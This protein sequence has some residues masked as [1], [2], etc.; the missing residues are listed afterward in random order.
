MCTTPKPEAIDH[1]AFNVRDLPNIADRVEVPFAIE[2]NDE[3]LTI[4]AAYRTSWGSSVEV[5]TGDAVGDLVTMNLDGS[6]MAEFADSP[7]V[8]D[9]PDEVIAYTTRDGEILCA[10]HGAPF[11]I[12]V[13]D[14]AVY[15]LFSG[16]GA[17]LDAVEYCSAGTDHGH[18]FCGSCGT[19]L[20]TLKGSPGRDVEGPFSRCS[21]CDTTS[22]YVDGEGFQY[23]DGFGSILETMTA[24]VRGVS[25]YCQT[26]LDGT[27]RIRE[28]NADN[29]PFGYYNGLQA[30]RAYVAWLEPDP[31][32]GM[33]LIICESDEEAFETADEWAEEKLDTS[34]AADEEEAESMLSDH[35]ADTRVVRV[36]VDKL[37]FSPKPRTYR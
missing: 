17:N 37:D 34:D 7:T 20:E 3:V 30:L 27:T 11:D 8:L 10:D 25:A 22:V 19:Y 33:V 4:H 29:A 14:G 5:E 28:V 2:M 9:A 36:D 32:S 6:C 13:D 23:V 35:R 15:P 24:T 26:N 31:S 18:S 1:G 21:S 16:Q 12:G